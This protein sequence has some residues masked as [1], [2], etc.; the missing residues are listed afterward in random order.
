MLMIEKLIALGITDVVKISNYSY[1][2]SSID[3]NGELFLGNVYG[4][5]KLVTVRTRNMN[6]GD[7]SEWTYIGQTKECVYY[8]EY[9]EELKTFGWF[10]KED[11]N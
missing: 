4:V 5:Q 1:F 9:D 11:L 3:T 2:N 8:L 6:N 7:S 10:Y